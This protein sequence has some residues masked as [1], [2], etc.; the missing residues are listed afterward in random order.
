MLINAQDPRQ[1]T[2]LRNLSQIKKKTL[3][4]TN[5][6]KKAVGILHTRWFCV[7]EKFQV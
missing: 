4:L 6:G 3:V 1:W 7:F 5:V 2:Y